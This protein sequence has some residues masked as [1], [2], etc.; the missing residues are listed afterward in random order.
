M[1]AAQSPDAQTSLDAQAAREAVDILQHTGATLIAS[2]GDWNEAQQAI[3]RQVLEELAPRVVETMHAERQ[4]LLDRLI[5]EMFRE[6]YPRYFSAA[7]L[8]ELAAYY[9]SPT[10]KK[11][12][13]L[14]SRVESEARRTGVDKLTLWRQYAPA[15][16][17]VD[18][19]LELRAFRV[20]ALGGKLEA[21]TPQLY[22]DWGVWWGPRSRAVIDAVMRD[23]GTEFSKRMRERQAAV[24]AAGAGRD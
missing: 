18:E 20:S 13:P 9:A 22:R 23:Y 4:L 1:I 11:M 8:S 14:W 21:V 12:R 10:Y 6:T 7:E 15:E 24:D 16:L 17:S 3:A 5:P 2:N 19:L